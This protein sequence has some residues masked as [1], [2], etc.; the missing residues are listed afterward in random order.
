M[1]VAGGRAPPGRGGG[2]TSAHGIDLSLVTRAPIAKPFNLYAKLGTTYGR[3]EATS[4][5]R[6]GLPAGKASGW[7][8][9]YGVGVGYDLSPG[10][11]I[12]LEWRRHDFHFTGGRRESV[13]ATSVGY[14]LRF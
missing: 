2:R 14:L 4:D 11:A 6:S 3:T 5:L 13:D 1:P 7:G 12:V 9:S 8:A 10:S